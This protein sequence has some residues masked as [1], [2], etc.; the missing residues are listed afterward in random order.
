MSELSLFLGFVGIVSTLSQPVGAAIQAPPG[1]ERAL[2]GARMENP[3]LSARAIVERAT[4]VAGGETW[5][6]PTTLYLEGYGTF[7]ATDGTPLINESHKMWRVYPSFKPEAHNADGKVRIESVR[8]GEVVSYSAFDGSRTYDLNGILP[9][10]AADTQWAE[11]FGFGVIRFAL[12]DGYS[13]TRQPDDLVDGQGV[14]RVSVTDASGAKTL[15]GISRTTYQ[16]VSVGFTTPRGWHERIYSNFFTKRGVN[17]VQPGRVRL[18][19]NGVKQNE[20]VWRDFKI[21]DPMPD[22]LFGVRTLNTGQ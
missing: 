14:F 1:P 8:G 13:L 11:N 22:T 18:Y 7:Y 16:I 6:R 4:V 10:S 21:N 17:W 20:I 2:L 9:P 3:N 15:F 12:D 19:Y 5:R